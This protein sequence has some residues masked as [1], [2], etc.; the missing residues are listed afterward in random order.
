M[1]EL[2]TDWYFNAEL[3]CYQVGIFH[4]CSINVYKRPGGKWAV[5]VIFENSLEHLDAYD[6]SEEA[7][8][9]ALDRALQIVNT[10]MTQ[11]LSLK[12]KKLNEQPD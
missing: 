9:A 12:W 3:N 6:T 7:K 2:M 10:A 5:N 1:P 4:V 8:K 11:I